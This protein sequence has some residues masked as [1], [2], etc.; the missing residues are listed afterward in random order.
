MISLWQLAN[1]VMQCLF[2]DG[3]L[4][5]IYWFICVYACTCLCAAEHIWKP[6]YNPQELGQSSHR[7]APREE[8][9]VV[10]VWWQTCL[11]ASHF[12]CW[13]I[14]TTHN[15][16]FFFNEIST[17]HLT[18]QESEFKNKPTEAFCVYNQEIFQTGIS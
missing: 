11:V 2:L 15:V 3:F 4:P 8:T 9:L 14:L 5:F 12:T 18:E 10:R 16:C 17:L 1:I 7:M 13:S 6:E